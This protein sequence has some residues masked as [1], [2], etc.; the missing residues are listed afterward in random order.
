MRELSQTKSAI[1]TRKWRLDNPEKW[2]KQYCRYMEANREKVKE[3]R[4]KYREANREELAERQRK[5]RE[6][7]PEYAREFNQSPEGKAYYSAYRQLPAVKAAA[8]VYSKAYGQTPAGKAKSQRASHARRAHLENALNTLT[9]DE[10]QAILEAHDFRCAYC[11][12]SLLDLFNPP[13]RDHVT[14]VSK[15]GDNIKENVVPACRWCNTS[16]GNKIISE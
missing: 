8:K 11:G 6:D 15:G 14:P 1:S 16:K 4:R 3:Y 13:T 10:W 5:W 12:C 2:L 9:A 7:N